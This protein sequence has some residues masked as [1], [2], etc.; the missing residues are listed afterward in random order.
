VEG[1]KG[2]RSGADGKGGKGEVET[3]AERLNGRERGRRCRVGQSAAEEEDE[4]EKDG[5][6]SEDGSKEAVNGKDGGKDEEDEENRDDAVKDEEE[7]NE[8]EDNEDEDKE[9]EEDGSDGVVMEA[10]PRLVWGS[11]NKR[12]LDNIFAMRKDTKG[13]IEGGRQ[14]GERGN[15][16]ERTK[17]RG[18]VYEGGR[19]E[20]QGGRESGGME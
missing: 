7:E 15:E 9:E 10:F 5:K 11:G 8:E 4:E 6:E 3:V 18:G 1:G 12:T 13:C 17:K 14:G 20:R 2:P 19:N 16:W